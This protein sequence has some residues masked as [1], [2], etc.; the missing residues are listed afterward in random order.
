MEGGEERWDGA[1][2]RKGT[3]REEAESVRETRTT[4]QRRGRTSDERRIEEGEGYLQ[5]EK[6]R[7]DRNSPDQRRMMLEADD[8]SRNDRARLGKE[9]DHVVL[10]LVDER[11]EE[12]QDIERENDGL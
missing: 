8:E 4:G 2:A 9:E 3:K 1:G 12:A 7:R 5:S 11:S 10:V 6:L